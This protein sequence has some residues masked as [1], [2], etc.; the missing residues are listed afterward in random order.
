MKA[1]R[2]CSLKQAIPSLAIL[3]S[4]QYNP[5]AL[6]RAM[7][8][9]L[10]ALYECNLSSPVHRVYGLNFPF[11]IPFPVLY[12]LWCTSPRTGKRPM[13]MAP[14]LKVRTYRIFK[15]RVE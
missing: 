10:L 2:E 13:L 4:A 14:T 1:D 15:C 6:V 8:K 5:L 12:Y 9:L 11:P 3:I 7:H